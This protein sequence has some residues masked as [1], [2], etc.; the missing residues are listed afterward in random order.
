[1]PRGALASQ[2]EENTTTD[3]QDSSRRVGPEG[4]AFVFESAGVVRRPSLFGCT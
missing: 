1:M 3:P 2:V 4:F